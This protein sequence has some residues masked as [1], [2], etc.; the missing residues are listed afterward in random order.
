MSTLEK[1]TPLFTRLTYIKKHGRLDIEWLKRLRQRSKI[2]FSKDR[3]DNK[4]KE[5]E[6]R[7]QGLH[8][9]R[10]HVMHVQYAAEVDEAP[11]SM[12]RI[13]NYRVERTASSRLHE[14]LS[15]L[16]QCETL[17]EHSAKI[18]LNVND[19]KSETRKFHFDIVWSCPGRGQETKPLSLSVETFAAKPHGFESASPHNSDLQQGLETALGLSVGHCS[20]SIASPANEL[21]ITSP[22]PDLHR[23]PNLCRY[24][25]QCSPDATIHCAGF[26]QKSEPFRHVIYTPGDD[27]NKT[28]RVINSLEEV[29]KVAKSASIAIPLPEKFQL[30]KLLALAV[31]RFYSTPW[32]G[33]GLRSKD[34]VFVDLQEVSLDPFHIPCLKSRV[35]ISS[36]GEDQSVSGHTT[37]N[38]Q[39]NSGQ[40]RSP[41]RNQTLYSLGVLLVELAYNSPLQDLQISEDDQGDPHTLYWAALRLG[42]RVWRELGQKYAD[43]VKICLYGGFGASSELDDPRVQKQFFDEVVRKLERCAEAVAI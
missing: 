8:R 27:V 4:L 11:P 42:D 10:K 43:A 32:L 5:L 16:W 33:E 39:G 22:L 19:D 20:L 41:V 34:V 17:E 28:T 13:A 2:S 1:R 26:L 29:L 9:I 14:V 12:A 18:C 23:I 40:L 37:I 36:N 6:N 24:L 3:Y 21:P 35:L 30:A 7:V 25:R 38:S 15:S 31:L